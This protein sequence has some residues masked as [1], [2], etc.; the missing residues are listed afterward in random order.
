[1]DMNF[2]YK[3]LLFLWTKILKSPHEDLQEFSLSDN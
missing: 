3:A 1:M 2:Y